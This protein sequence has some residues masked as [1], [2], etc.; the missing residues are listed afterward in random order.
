[1]WVARL[2]Q[3]GAL[4][5]EFHA[6]SPFL[7]VEYCDPCACA[8]GVGITYPF[9]E[10]AAG[11][12]DGKVVVCGVFNSFGGLGTKDVGRL[13]PD[14]SVD[15]TF[16]VSPAPDGVVQTLAL[17]ADGKIVI[18]GCFSTVGG[19]PRNRLARLNTDGSLDM[20]FDPDAGRPAFGL[21]PVSVL[22]MQPDGRLLVGGSFYGINGLQRRNLAR[23]Q[24][25]VLLFDPIATEVGFSARIGTL[26]GRKYWLEFNRSLST[27]DWL[28][29]ASLVGD[30]TVGTFFDNASDGPARFYR[31]R[32]D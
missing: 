13:N 11:Q 19:V 3:N 30:G 15:T 27:G 5:T 8:P 20:T 12:P 31:V 16:E 22:A 1:L 24:G 14:G 25:E 6:A 21:P 4:D 7:G 26:A 23:L 18:G 29:V 17:Q 9:L 32:V 28:P 10:A 2:L